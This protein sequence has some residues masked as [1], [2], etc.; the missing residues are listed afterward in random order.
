MDEAEML[1]QGKIG[2]IPTDTL[3]GL[4]AAASD[5]AA[6]ERVYALKGRT[7]SKPCI[8][9]ISSLDDLAQFGLAPTEKRRETL[10]RY[11]PGPVSIVLACGPGIPEYLHRGTKSLAFRLPDDTR[12]QQFLS[13]S[14]PLIAPSA[15][16]EGLPPATSI[17]EAAG[18]FGN[19]VDFYIDGSSRLGT[20]STLIALD[21]HDSIKIIREGAKKIS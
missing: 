15:N 2:V 11:W 1:R 14:G 10:S 8:I 20:R 7:P 9:L 21:E 19:H 17:E 6:V 12:L 16:P 18:Y 4:V 3:Y 13:K 5:E